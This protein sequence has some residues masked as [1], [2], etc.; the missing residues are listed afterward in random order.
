MTDQNVN[1]FDRLPNGP[2]PFADVA[3]RLHPTLDNV[4]VV[5]QPLQARTRL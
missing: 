3:L 1:L 4:G 2:V 5:K